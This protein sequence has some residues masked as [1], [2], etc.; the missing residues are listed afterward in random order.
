MTSTISEQ[1]KTELEEAQKHMREA[2][3]FAARTESPFLVKHI[4][5]MLFDI[6]HI[7]EVDD[8][9]NAVSLDDLA[10]IDGTDL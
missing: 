7:Q 9:L 10:K 3:S 2:L 6:G 1:V 5:Q 8:L 4:S